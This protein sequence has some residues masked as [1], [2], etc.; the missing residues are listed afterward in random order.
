MDR[1]T[2]LGRTRIQRTA[3]KY[4]CAQCETTI[5]LGSKAYYMCGRYEGEWYSYYSH[6]ECWDAAEEF[7]KFNDLWDDEFPWWHA[8]DYFDSGP[9]L[10][11]HYP[12]VYQR[13][14]WDDKERSFKDEES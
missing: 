9:W 3:K 13:L 12:I 10:K 11:E 14:G 4:P 1:M 8:E 6:I 5:K 7:A 2:D